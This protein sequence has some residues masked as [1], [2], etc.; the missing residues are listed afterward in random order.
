MSVRSRGGGP[1]PNPSEAW[2]PNW[3]LQPTVADGRHF[4]PPSGARG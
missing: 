2:L 1:A 4:V 3:P